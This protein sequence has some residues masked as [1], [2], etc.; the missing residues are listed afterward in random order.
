MTLTTHELQRFVTTLASSEKLWRPHV[1]HA[2]DARVYE[3]IWEDDNVNAWLICWSE[4]QD[5]GFH[6]HDQSAAAIA[7]IDGQ[8]CEERLRIARAPSTRIFNSRSTF[9]V[10]PEAIHRVRHVGVQ[11]AVT[12]HAYS[13]PLVRSGAYWIGTDGELVRQPQSVEEELRAAAVL[14]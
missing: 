14:S 12:V 4:D 10:P 2:D 1:R 9:T 8:V 7:V 5:T 3:L 11:P 13:P 6:Y